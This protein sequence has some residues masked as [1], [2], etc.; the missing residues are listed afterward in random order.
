[1]ERDDTANYVA[2]Y[3]FPESNFSADS[4]AGRKT[5]DWEFM[6]DSLPIKITYIYA[7]A[8]VYDS[9]GF[10]KYTITKSE[11]TYVEIDRISVGYQQF[12]YLTEKSTK[13]LKRLLLNKQTDFQQR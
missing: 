11:R 1:M 3:K 7:L 4:P 8:A 6:G 10:R 2:I 13:Q 12:R 5:Y 9:G